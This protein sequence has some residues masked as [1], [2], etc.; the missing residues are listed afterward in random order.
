MKPVRIGLRLMLLLVTLVAVFLAGVGTLHQT[1]RL[2]LIPL[3]ERIESLELRR[4]EIQ[5][6]LKAP[7]TG[8]MASARSS[9]AEVD[10]DIARLRKRLNH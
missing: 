7:G 2:R 8:K 9:L 4:A 6:Q 5:R 1:K 3:V 10:A